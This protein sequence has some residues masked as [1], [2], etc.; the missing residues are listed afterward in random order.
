MIILEDGG[1]IHGDNIKQ[2]G[3]I[4]TT[5]FMLQKD[6]IDHEDD[7]NGMWFICGRVDG[8]KQKVG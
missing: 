7:D 3:D 4:L 8:S 5:I 6:K 2:G 1:G